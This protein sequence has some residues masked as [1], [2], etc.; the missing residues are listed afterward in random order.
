LAHPILIGYAI[1]MECNYNPALFSFILELL[2]Y[3]IL[4]RYDVK[5]EWMHCNTIQYNTIQ[6]NT[7]QYNTIQYNTIQYNTPGCHTQY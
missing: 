5:M 4:I 2:T 7:I 1:K 6:Y 3:S